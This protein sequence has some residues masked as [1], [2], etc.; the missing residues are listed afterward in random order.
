MNVSF[1][2]ISLQFHVFAVLNNGFNR[3]DAGI[4]QKYSEIVKS[5]SWIVRNN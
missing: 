2:A 3:I 5:L 4:R 1:C